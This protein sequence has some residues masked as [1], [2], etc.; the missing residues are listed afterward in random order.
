[1]FFSVII[2]TYNRGEYLKRALRSVLKQRIDTNIGTDTDF[3]N[4]KDIKD[5]K[6][7]VIIIDDGSIDGSRDLVKDLLLENNTINYVYFEQN[8]GV[9]WARNKGIELAKG[10]WICFLDSDD[11][12]IKEKLKWTYDYIKNNKHIRVIHG[13]EIWIRNGVRVNQMKKHKKYGGH[14]FEKCLPLCLISP[15]AVTIHK[16]IF[17]E[18]GLF[19]EDFTVCED[20]ELWLRITFKEEIGFID[21][22]IIIKYGG[23]EDQLSKR[24]V[25]M[26]YYRI[27][28]MVDF[29]KREFIDRVNTNKNND[30]AD[31]NEANGI[32]FKKSILK[33]II[34]KS[35]ILLNGYVKHNN[36]NEDY[37]NTERIYKFAKSALALME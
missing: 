10:E 13:D 37:Q 16:D 24:Y 28:A 19:R 2:P 20:Y 25:A 11:E 8:R 15:S 30:V 18:I 9:S 14:I 21:R 34:S 36:L 22:P 31:I 12:W 4:I 5:I 1:M 3:K 7:E 32:I 29:F 35:Q 33:E 26:D 6:F 23:H 17:K 27:V